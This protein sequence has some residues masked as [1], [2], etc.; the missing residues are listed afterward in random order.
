MDGK[1]SRSWARH[2]DVPPLGSGACGGSG[3]HRYHG[4]WSRA[5]KKRL[6]SSLDCEKAPSDTLSRHRETVMAGAMRAKQ[7]KA[8]GV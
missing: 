1:A 2:G 8:K 6:H 5:A 7:S 4:R 3:V